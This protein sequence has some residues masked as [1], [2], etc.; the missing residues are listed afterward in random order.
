[1]R[2][3]IDFYKALEESDVPELRPWSVNT[4]V[5]YQ[6]QDG[7]YQGLRIGG[8]SR[9]Q[10]ARTVGFPVIPRPNAPEGLWTYDVTKPFMGEALTDYDLFAAYN[11]KL[12]QNKN[13]TTRLNVRNVFAS[14]ELIPVTVQPDGTPA[15]YRIAPPRTISITN[16][17]SF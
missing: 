13:L 2:Q 14:D 15:S 17:I 16:T 1:M 7:K 12:G 11:W 4:V 3:G 9:Y 5:S 8:S 10:D 6:F